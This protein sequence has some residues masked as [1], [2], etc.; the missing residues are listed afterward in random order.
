MGVIERHYSGPSA[1]TARTYQ[2]LDN[3]RA[4]LPVITYYT[5]ITLP[6]SSAAQTKVALTASRV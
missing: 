5:A 6:S 1:A 3:A 2:S 4:Y